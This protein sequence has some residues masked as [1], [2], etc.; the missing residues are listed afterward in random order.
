MSFKA[1][2]TLRFTSRVRSSLP[3]DT[4]WLLRPSH[5]SWTRG[6]SESQALR[7]EP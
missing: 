2:S 4:T 1:C 5:H 7:S 3:H 6:P